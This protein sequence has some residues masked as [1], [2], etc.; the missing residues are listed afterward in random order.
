MAHA[1]D[2]SARGRK[3][4]PPGISPNPPSTP[5][6]AEDVRA[7]EELLGRITDPSSPIF[8]AAHDIYDEAYALLATPMRLLVRIQQLEETLDEIANGELVEI[9]ELAV[10]ARRIAR[11]A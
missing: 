8:S 4:T 9:T 2:P 5:T 11:T 1:S 10:N 7:L 3:P 6:S